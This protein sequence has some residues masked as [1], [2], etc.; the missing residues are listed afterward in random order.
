MLDVLVGICLII[1]LAWLVGYPARRF[2][3]RAAKDLQEQ[4]EWEERI[5]EAAKH[6]QRLKQA[7]DYLGETE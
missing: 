3:R 2:N 5:I 7:L 1:P 6:Q 4:Q